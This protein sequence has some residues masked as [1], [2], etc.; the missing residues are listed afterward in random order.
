VALER[1]RA[2]L[3][4]WQ[5]HG[6]QAF[7]DAQAAAARASG[8]L[9]TLTIVPPPLAG[10]PGFNPLSPTPPPGLD[11][12]AQPGGLIL[13]AKKGKGGKAPTMVRARSRTG[14]PDGRGRV[15][16]AHTAAFGRFQETS[17]VP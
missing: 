14:H 12:P 2:E 11:D 13:P 6:Q 16:Q 10:L 5:L 4:H 1:A 8:H 7:D 3:T 15:G 9:E 17:P